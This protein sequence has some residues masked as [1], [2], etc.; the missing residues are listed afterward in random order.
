MSEAPELP[1]Y[2]TP[3]VRHRVYLRD[4]YRCRRCGE[5]DLSKL[6]VHHVKFRSQGGAHSED[7]LVTVCW[8]PCHQL[9]HDHRVTVTNVNGK[10]L[11]GD[12]RHWRWK[13]K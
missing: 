8:I 13:M 6:T 9:I 12:A 7:N 11:F 1:D 4:E 2:V 5:Q 10:W 3:E